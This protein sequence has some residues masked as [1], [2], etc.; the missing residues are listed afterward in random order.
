MKDEMGKRLRLPIVL[1][2]LC[3]ASLA[4][5]PPAPLILEVIPK[6][7]A[8]AGGEPRRVT[9]VA[10]ITVPVRKLTL[11]AR[12]D[13]GT[14]VAIG[15]PSESSEEIQGD[16]SWPVWINQSPDGRSSAHVILQARY[17]HGA[18]DNPV[19]GLSQAT[20]EITVKQRPKIEEIVTTK[21]EIS[22]D[23]LE[24][25]RPR[26]AYLE[27]T[28]VSDVPVEIRNVRGS[29]PPFAQL[30]AL[31][32]ASQKGTTAYPLDPDG[33]YQLFGATPGAKPLVITPRKQH[34]FH[35]VLSI[36]EGSQVLSGKYLMVVDVDLHYIKDGYSTDGDVVASKEFDAGVL[37]ETEF[38]GPTEVPFVLLPGFLFVALFT[39]LFG[40]FW[41]KWNI[42]FDYK[43]PE[44]YL[45][46]IVFSILAVL[47]YKP[48]SPLLY[49]YLWHRPNVPPRDY[50]EGY[51]ISDIMNVWFLAILAA[52]LIW[53]V[54]GGVWSLW[55]RISA[56]IQRDR[57]PDPADK[58][59]DLIRK[60]E[61]KGEPFDLKEVTVGGQRRWEIPL[62]SPDPAKK[63]VAGRIDVKFVDITREQE[64]EFQQLVKQTSKTKEIG[65][66]LHQLEG[67][68]TLSWNPLQ[69]PE[70]VAVNDAVAKKTPSE[71]F[72][73]EQV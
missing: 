19:T 8:L 39:L 53:I 50:F 22:V 52:L 66:F 67:K 27:L 30:S 21:L 32:P 6:D 16:V 1:A 10:R 5:Q 55:A 35:F 70:L 56:R 20:V 34:I 25:R 42:S 49:R 51:S 59:L 48:L 64:K 3:V 26:Q 29:L 2:L 4:D 73:H 9:V 7:L 44:T 61:R 72:I 36:P 54:I 13:P 47:A 60:L 28:N 37:G 57:T 40:R 38:V 58:P 15:K 12:A 71:P 33:W 17:E 23:K 45:G 24:E 69:P 18:R 46:G 68:V 14:R 63:W 31:T 62:P 43:K 41:P 11:Q 65:D